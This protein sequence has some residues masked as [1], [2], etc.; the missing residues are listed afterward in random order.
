MEGK[1]GMGKR[2]GEEG[3]TLTQSEARRELD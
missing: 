2:K 3:I 1:N